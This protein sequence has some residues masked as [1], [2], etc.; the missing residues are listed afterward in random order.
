MKMTKWHALVAHMAKH[1]NL[2]VG[3]FWV[4]VPGPGTP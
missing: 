3:P 2:V 4:G 1:M